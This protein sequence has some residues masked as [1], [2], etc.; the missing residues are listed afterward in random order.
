MDAVLSGTIP[1]FRMVPRDRSLILDDG[2]VVRDFFSEPPLEA[3]RRQIIELA[4]KDLE[5]QKWIIRG[6]VGGSPKLADA[7]GDTSRGHKRGR[8]HPPPSGGEGDP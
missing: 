2:T 1:L 3:A 7:S 5:Q 4:E 6:A 8:R